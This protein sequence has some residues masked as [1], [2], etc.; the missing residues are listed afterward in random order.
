[1]SRT[2]SKKLRR[3][4][5]YYGTAHRTIF[6]TEGSFASWRPTSVQRREG[7]RRGLGGCLRRIGEFLGGGGLL[8][9]FFHIAEMSTK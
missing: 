8:T 1:M 7:A 5:T 3:V 4:A 2:D 6:S 9:S